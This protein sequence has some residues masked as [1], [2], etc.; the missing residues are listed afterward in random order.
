[1]SVT[2][3]LSSSIRGFTY[4]LTI[5]NGNLST[6]VD[7]ALIT[8]QVRSVVETRYYERVIRANYGIADRILDVLDP[9]QVNSELQAS[10]SANV[11]GLSDLSVTGDWKTGGDDGV[12][13]VFIQY[14][15]NGVPQPP[16][17]FT[18]AN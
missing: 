11:P 14:S 7:Y 1:M 8:Q 3:P 18:L 15:V 4:P 13:H 17:Q 16:M 2:E 6:S 5:V 12:Y 10:I 9:G